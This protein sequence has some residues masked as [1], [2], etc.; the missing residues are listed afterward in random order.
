MKKITYTVAAL[1]CFWGSVVAQKADS[2]TAAYQPKKLKIEEVNFVSSYYHQNGNNSA[3]TGGIGTEKLYD[4][5]N[6]LELK[7]TKV[8]KRQRIHTI[9]GELNIDYYSSAS[10]DNIDPLTIS[11]ASLTDT[12]IYPSVSWNVKDE[13][14]RTS[15]GIS[16]LYSTEYDYHSYGMMFNYSKS[17]RDN[18]REATFKLGS[19]MDTYTAILPSELRPA[20]Y[21]SGADGDM[22]HLYYR[23]RNTYNSSLAVSQ[24]IN[25]RLQVMMIVEPTYQEGLLST[26]FHRTYFTDGSER[27]EKLPG[28]RTKVPIGFRS[29]YFAGDRVI[30]RTFYRY[31]AD[32]WG[33]HAHTASLEVPVKITPFVSLSPFYRFN[34]QKGVRY[35]APY[36]QHSPSANYY[37][38]DYD[39][40][41]F[42][43]H[44]A[45]LGVRV[46]PPGGIMGI[47][48]FASLEIRYGHFYRTAGTGMNSDMITLAAKL[49]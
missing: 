8:D 7:L 5:A 43:S 42:Q 28:S 15:K 44:F 2:T 31:Y 14:H 18:N 27:V 32:S 23:P 9:S 19:F 33:M 29:S 17:S 47:R 6:S 12:H 40:S 34:A 38:S 16:A 20:G 4:F 3:I 46:A 30:I 45:G 49:K 36:K 22:A 48:H 39:L 11:S 41:T 10:Q 26:P 1:M 35:F 25:K 24:I 13:A 37:T 21:S